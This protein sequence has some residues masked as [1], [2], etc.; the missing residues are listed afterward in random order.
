[1]DEKFK[2]RPGVKCNEA[3][4]VFRARPNPA[5]LLT[6]K[7]IVPKQSSASKTIENL[8][9]KWNYLKKEEEEAVASIVQERGQDPAQRGNRTL[10]Q[11]PHHHTAVKNNNIRK[12]KWM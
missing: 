6:R 8:F 3:K 10:K 7:S 4:N 12:D 5:K 11:W 9:N 2:E 1:M